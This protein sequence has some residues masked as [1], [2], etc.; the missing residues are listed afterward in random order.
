MKR[1][2]W[3]LLV[4]V[5]LTGLAGCGSLA[6]SKFHPPSWIQGEWA[7]IYGYNHFKFTDDNIILTTT[8]LSID[9]KAVY[10]NNVVLE[11]KT[12]TLYEVD[13]GDAKYKFEKTTDTK[14][15]YWNTTGGITF[16]PIE[17][18]KQ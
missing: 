4:L 6:P 14:L 2:A 16:G 15:K 17:L 12:D 13:I 18:T 9:F 5:L 8:N 7:D 10:K 11:T 3:V 1:I